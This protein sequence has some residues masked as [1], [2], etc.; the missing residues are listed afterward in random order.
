MS[1][2]TRGDISK[3]VRSSCT[4]LFNNKITDTQFKEGLKEILLEYGSTGYILQGIGLALHRVS[5][6]YS[7]ECEQRVWSLADQV[8][9]RIRDLYDKRVDE[10]KK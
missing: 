2:R 5:S 8:D 1:K 4:G 7:S 3:K 9:T 6:V 10:M